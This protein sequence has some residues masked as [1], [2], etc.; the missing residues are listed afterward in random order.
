MTDTK[1][2]LVWRWYMRLDS[3]G[4]VQMNRQCIGRTYDPNEVDRI[5]ST[6][7]IT[8]PEWENDTTQFVHE[9]ENPQ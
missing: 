8:H 3:R 1:V 6:Y 5:I 4:D 7:K 9:E 2:T